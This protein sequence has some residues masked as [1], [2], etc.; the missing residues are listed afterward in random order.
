MLSLYKNQVVT[1][2]AKAQVEVRQL[3][4][5]WYS[6]N[7]WTLS[8]QAAVVGGFAYAQLTDSTPDETPYLLEL[9]Y[10]LVTAV[11]FGFCLIVVTSC[12][13]ACMWSTGLALRG[14]HGTKSVH[15]AVE[16][17]HAQQGPMFA[18]FILAII[19]FY[20]SQ[21]LLLFVFYESSVAWVVSIPFA[22]FLVAIIYYTMDLTSRLRVK[23]EDSTQGKIEILKNYEQVPDLDAA[24][25]N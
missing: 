10:L 22:I 15:L 17:L 5:D 6:A 24:Y 18:D 20:V 14:P 25:G 12:T 9:V 8:S 13:L 11:S 2:V 7:F 23:D 16:N 21:M 19:T 1:Q 4:L 3:E